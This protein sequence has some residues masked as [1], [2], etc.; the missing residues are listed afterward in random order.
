ML[1]G[2]VFYLS[3][4]YKRS[5]L[6]SRVGVFYAAASIS[7]AFSGLIAYGVFHID[8]PRYHSW[9]FLFWIEGAAT[10]MFATFAWFWL[11]RSTSTW[12]ALTE[13]EKVL[14]RVRILSD[15]SISVDE[16]L[17]ITDAFRPLKDPV[18][19]VWGA[20]SFSLGVPLASVNNFLPQ[21]VHSMGYSTVKTNLYTVA[22][23]VAATVALLALTFSSDHFRERS[24]H[25]SIALSTTIVGFIV[26]GAIDPVAKKDVAYFACFLIAMGAFA[27]SV[28]VASWYSNNTLSESRRA[29]TAAVM[30]A[31]ANS[32]GL[33]STNVFRAKDEPKYTP[34]L[35]TSAIFGATCLCLTLA[36]GMY[37]RWENR[38]RN[39][40]QGVNLRAQDVETEAL[41]RGKDA[42]AFRYMY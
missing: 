24:I 29:V 9:Q 25:I 28:L 35:I 38:R 13:R 26:L 14:A 40:E 5:E 2:V 34:A 4:F 42:P 21:I 27:P 15:S 17:D 39:R 23:N 16:K 1:P 37:Q 6:A 10:V 19:W 18:Y 30:V 8:H 36:L 32:A 33:I 22:P 31:L 7:G 12:W 20:I 41:G 11:P 3:T